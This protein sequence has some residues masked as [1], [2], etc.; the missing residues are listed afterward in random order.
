MT[1][2]ATVHPLVD[3][4]IDINISYMRGQ[5]F[6]PPYILFSIN[7]ILFYFSIRI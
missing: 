7:I 1:G 5:Y 6:I 4:K 2:G 3:F